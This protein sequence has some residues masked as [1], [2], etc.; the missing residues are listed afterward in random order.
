MGNAFENNMCCNGTD[1]ENDKTNFDLKGK[2][3]SFFSDLKFKILYQAT[4]LIT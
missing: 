3:L 4:K 1:R 2:L